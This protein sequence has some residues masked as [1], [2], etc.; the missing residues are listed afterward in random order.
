[1]IPLVIQNLI[2][3]A[4]FV[5]L[6]VAAIMLAPKPEFEDARAKGLG[7][8]QIPT[9][10]EAR[11]VPIVWGTAEL[12]GPNV[13]WYGDL[14]VEE[15]EEEVKTGWFSSDTVVIG[16]RYFIGVHLLLCY[17]QLDRFTWFESND[18]ELWSGS[19]SP[20]GSGGTVININEPFF[21]GQEGEGGGIVG[22]LR[23]YGGGPNQ[24]P[25]SYLEDVVSSLMPGYVDI[26]HVV[27]EQGE[28]GES[29]RLG[30]WAFRVT[31]FPNNLSLTG[32]NYIARG[33]IDDGD[34]NPAEVLYEILTNTVWGLQ[35]SPSDIDTVSFQDAGNTL[36][37]EGLGFGMVLDRL[38]NAADIIKEILRQVDGVLYEDT[39]GKFYFNLIREDY[40]VGAL[41]IFAEDN[42]IEVKNF[43]RGAWT[44]TFNHVNV[45]YNDRKK[46]FIK[47]GAFAQDI[48][49]V[50]TQNRHVRADFEYPGVKSP[51]TANIVARRELRH[52]SFP[53]AKVSLIVNR[54]GQS[55]RP[56]SPFRFY[57]D[58]LGISNMILRVLTIDQGELLDGQVQLECAQDMFQLSET[59]YDDPGDSGW[60]PVE[61]LATAFVDELVRQAPRLGLNQSPQFFPDPT[62][63][64]ILSVAKK[65]SG[66]V[67]EFE[68]WVDVGSG[69][70]P[71]AGSSTGTTPFGKL[72]NAYP[73]NTAD[74]EVSDL[75]LFD[76]EINTQR[77]SNN[78]AANIEQGQNLALIQGAASDGSEDE[79][80][81]WEQ[82][83][84]EGDGTWTLRN[85]HRGLCDTQARDHAALAKLWFVSNGKALSALT[86]DDTSSINVKHQSETTTD[87]LDITSATALPLTFNQRSVRPHHPANFTVNATRLPVA[88][89]ETAD[90]DFDWEHRLNTDV[91][92]LD[93]DDASTG[94]Q[95]TEVEYDLE[96]RHAVTQ[97]VL[98]SVTQTSPGA[99]W[100]T[101]LYTA[102]NLRTDTGEVGDFPLEVSMQARYAAA[103][104]NNPANLTSLQDLVFD[105]N[106]DMGSA[107]VQSVVLNGTT[108][109]LANTS[110][111]ITNVADEWSVSVW[112]RGTSAAGG[113]PRSI[114][115]AKNTAS[116][117]NR[118][119][120]ILTDDSAASPYQI[121]TWDSSGTPFKDYSFGSYTQN[122]WTLIT[123]TWDGTNLTVYQ[124]GSAQTPTLTTDN[125]G[126]M[127]D[128]GGRQIIVG[129]DS[130]LAAQ[131]WVGEIFSP[132]V[133]SAELGATEVAA[134]ATGLSGFNSRVNSGNYV[135]RDSLV[136][137]WDFRQSTVP[138]L[139]QDY[140]HLT[141]NLINIYT[142]SAFIGP[143]DLNPSQ[144]P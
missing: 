50:H 106:V 22:D 118:I 83:I 18:M 23:V 33:D 79:I 42:I 84:D 117:N 19:I 96:F 34:A 29:E 142:N 76:N 85:V 132:K 46:D 65:E 59:L 125:P 57:W 92:L 137:L 11:A 48:A 136:H 94:S 143:S 120:L 122:T 115:L 41:P 28:I 32:S 82:L 80:I 62:L 6:F 123:V 105:F 40:V 10:S 90:L 126:T 8:L 12:R 36:A 91:L 17:G 73:R 101:Y 74:L 71:R 100:L 116:N 51:R 49:N 69:Y 35:I 131:Y 44:Q 103:A 86:Y 60:S 99:P 25:S 14:L 88:T 95:D 140:G 20:S 56:G 58:K 107:T 128:T 109:Y 9:A 54:E 21:F 72:V 37:D 119:E 102:I 27:W 75:L 38:T 52:L 87:A 3:L 112:T 13:L 64:R 26:A 24:N 135:S 45:S 5:A 97:A 114:F 124:D 63:A 15:I 110:N 43:S 98:R 113:T 30:R 1:M 70:E 139:G 4:L 61:N 127:N 121:Q 130:T 129:V 7:D 77:L 66:Q 67:I 133:W 134:I 2:L 141:T 144:V 81:G 16:H 111:T 93:A 55:L 68:Q 138:A 47:T 53:F 39:D 31:R 89:D 108:K 104:V 78:V